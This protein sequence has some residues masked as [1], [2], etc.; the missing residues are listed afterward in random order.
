MSKKAKG[1]TL[2]ELMVVIVIVG[3]LAAVSVPIYRNYTQG[4]M[5][6]EGRALASAV[7]NAEKIFMAQNS[8]YRPV[9]TVTAMDAQLKVDA[10]QNRYFRDYTV[11]VA[12]AAFTVITT[13]AGASEA[14]GINVT[15]IQPATAG[16]TIT[17]NL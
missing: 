2:V 15:Y 8:S 1:F 17:D 7:A 3:I 12:G 16:P 4:A 6:A 11:T 10:T 9:G 13:G 14:S 5:A